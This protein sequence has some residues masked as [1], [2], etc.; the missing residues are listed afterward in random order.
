MNRTD[1]STFPPTTLP[2]VPSFCPLRTLAYAVAT[3]AFLTPNLA[4]QQGVSPGRIRSIDVERG[5]I[6][7]RN[8]NTRE[9]QEF[10]V[11]APTTIIDAQGHALPGGLRNEGF[12]VGKQVRIMVRPKEVKNVLVG[13]MLVGDQPGQLPALPVDMT[14]VKPLAE[15]GS[16]EKYKGFEGG[17]YPG[18]RTNGRR[19]TRRR[20]GRWRGG[21]SRSTVRGSRVR[22]GRSWSCRSG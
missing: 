9:E 6:A 17:L 7:I 19:G 20:G 14:G 11:A 1:R 22:R 4:A 3:I 15:M 13:L 21:S 2:S 18:G 16:G 8:G 5:T 10:V 12:Q